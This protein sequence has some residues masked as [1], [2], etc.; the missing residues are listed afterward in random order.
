MVT[1]TAATSY[2]PGSLIPGVTYYWMV[3]ANNAG[4]S[5]SS[6]VW[7]FITTNATTASVT[8]SSGSGASQTF[9][10]QYSDTA[11]ASSLQQVW[12]YFNATLANPASNACLLYYNV[13][14]NQI[15]LLGDNGT[16]L[17]GGDPGI[18]GDVAE[19]PML[20]QCGG[21]HGMHR[22]ATL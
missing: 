13:V 20:G 2:A 6:P 12:V 18:R 9:A 22:A 19:Q 1:S 17:A 16:S 5:N 21:C 4:G 15:N 7:S 8:P 10:L 14:T 11:G 3:V